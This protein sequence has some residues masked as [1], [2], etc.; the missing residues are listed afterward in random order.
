MAAGESHETKMIT[1]LRENTIKEPEV[2]NEESANELDNFLNE[3]TFSGT[4]EANHSNMKFGKVLSVLNREVGSLNLVNQLE[5]Y[6][7]SR[8]E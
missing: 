5:N 3:K 6:K 2:G 4:K 1:K 8:P 7:Q